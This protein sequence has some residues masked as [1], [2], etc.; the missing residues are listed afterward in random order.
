M[1]LPA[2]K[3]V[4]ENL[5][6]VLC[7]NNKFFLESL[8]TNFHCH[9]EMRKLWFCWKYSYYSK[10]YLRWI[11]CSS[12]YYTVKKNAVLILNYLIL[13]ANKKF[14]SFDYV[15]IAYFKNCVEDCQLPD[16]HSIPKYVFI[17]YI[18]K[19]TCGFSC[20]NLYLNVV[21]TPPPASVSTQFEV[22]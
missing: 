18:C 15:W 14:V 13:I 1:W 5:L 17:Y 9:N 21:W 7:L 10:H 11:L 3:A 20:N 22:L 16:I 4:L 2:G 8:V 12:T 6:Q 19:L